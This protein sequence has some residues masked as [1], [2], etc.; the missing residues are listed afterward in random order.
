MREKR[1]ESGLTVHA[2]A[3]THVVYIGT[4]L[5][6]AKRKGCLGFAVQREDHTED[7][8]TWMR[9]L[10]TFEEVE[11]FPD[12]GVQVS[13]HEHP[14]Q[15]FQWADYTAKPGHDYTY[16]VIPLYGKPSKLVDGDA[17]SVKVKMESEFG[18]KHSVFFNRG[19]VASQ[20][21]ARRFQN[22]EPSEVGE[23]AYRWLS[24]GLLEALLAFIGRAKDGSYGLYGAVY[25][26]QWPAALG[27]TQCP[28]RR[29]QAGRGGPRDLRR[30][31][32]RQR[33]RR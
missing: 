15:S 5:T 27:G 22:R 23:I 18:S 25:E 11:P 7:E 21:Y 12:P 8:R 26:F 2:I 13:S 6:N 20:E 9:G 10:K 3:G 19:A 32:R 28:A 17:V 30:D 1:T 4:D 31:P 16:T 29:I 14:F 24:R 33:A